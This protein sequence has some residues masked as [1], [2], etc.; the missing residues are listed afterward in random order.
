[1]TRASFSTADSLQPKSESSLTG[2]FKTF[3]FTKERLKDFGELPRGEIPTALQVDPKFDH[4]KL[5]NG[6]QIGMEHFDGHHSG[7][8]NLKLV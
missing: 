5:D 1:L 3:Q 8:I 4:I 6:V 2:K 7:K